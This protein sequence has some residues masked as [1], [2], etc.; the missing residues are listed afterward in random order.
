[1]ISDFDKASKKIEEGEK[2]ILEKAKN[3]EALR[4]KVAS[5]DNPWQA[6]A[7]RSCH[8][9]I[10]SIDHSTHAASHHQFVGQTPS[11]APAVDA[12]MDVPQPER[13]PERDQ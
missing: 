13:K 1:M 3:A 11:C 8:Q 9:P 7:R 5:C 2:K 12:G 6:S 4:Q 10:E